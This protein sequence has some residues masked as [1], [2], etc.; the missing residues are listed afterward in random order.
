[1]S[2][3]SSV[4]DTF[5]IYVENRVG[6]SRVARDADVNV[7]D[8]FGLVFQSKTNERGRITIDLEP[9]IYMIEVY[10]KG[11]RLEKEIRISGYTQ[12]TVKI[13]LQPESKN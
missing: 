7:Y 13:Y 12:G 3:K 11:L 8:N 10:Y 1:M 9:G 2:V 6:N 5:Q 4:A